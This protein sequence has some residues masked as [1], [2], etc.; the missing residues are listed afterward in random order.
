VSWSIIRDD[1]TSL[2]GPL[3]ITAGPGT[4]T[5]SYTRTTAS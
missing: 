1:D 3:T 4:V 5:V 2:T